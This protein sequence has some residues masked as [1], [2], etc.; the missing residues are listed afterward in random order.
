MKKLIS[1]IAIIIMT[2]LIMP[3]CLSLQ[4][5]KKKMDYLPRETEIPGWKLKG[6]MVE[7]TAFAAREYCQNKGSKI[8]DDS[9][10]NMFYA[11]YKPLAFDKSEMRIEIYRFTDS[12]DSFAVLSQERGFNYTKS[13]FGMDGYQS[14]TSICW[15]KEN[16]Y[17]KITIAKSYYGIKKDLFEFARITD[18]KVPV[19]KDILPDSLLFLSSN[20]SRD[21]VIFYKN[22]FPAI[23]GLQNVAIRKVVDS[24]VEYQ[25]FWTKRVSPYDVQKDIAMLLNDQTKKFVML[26]SDVNQLIYNNQPGGELIAAQ[27][28][29][30]IGIDGVKSLTDAQSSGK[31]LFDKLKAYKLQSGSN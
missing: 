19:T 12:L 20:N 11:E 10:V 23:P 28:E 31:M 4:K 21:G 6:D 18:T 27:N 25:V 1:F 8:F 14:D 29:W 9:L 16:Y 2:T 3:G 13:D 22:N 7:L 26:S 17:F 15:R 24:G 30:L 5:G